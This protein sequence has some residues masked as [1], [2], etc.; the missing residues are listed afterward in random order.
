M[1]DST[2]SNSKAYM[3]VSVSCIMPID[4]S[5][6]CALVL[7]RAVAVQDVT[8]LRM[9]CVSNTSLYCYIYN[10]MSVPTRA[11]QHCK[12]SYN[13]SCLSSVAVVSQLCCWTDMPL[14]TPAMTAQTWHISIGAHFPSGC[15]PSANAALSSNPAIIACKIWHASITWCHHSPWGACFCQH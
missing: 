3:H 2:P 14:T 13:A 9:L 11:G 10:V 5:S 15:S 7:V 12:C 8:D 6:D 4:A 1:P